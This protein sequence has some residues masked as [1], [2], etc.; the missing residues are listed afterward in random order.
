MQAIP[1]GEGRI[2]L[3][4]SVEDTGMGIAPEDKSRIFA[5]FEQT[6]QGRKREAGVG[7]GLAISRELAHRMGGVIEVDSQPGSGSRFSFS[8]VLPVVEVQEAVAPARLHIAGYEGKRRSILV[9]DDQEENRQLLRRM[10]ELLG[11]DVVLAGD[12][13]EAIAAARERH[14]DLIMMDLR[15]PGT[16]GFEAARIIRSMPGLETVPLMAASASTAD[17]EHAE[18]DP[19][20]FA[21]C[22]RKPF[23]TSDLIDAIERSLHLKWRY[24]QPGGATAAEQPQ[25]RL[26]APPR[27]VLITLLELA[28][29]GKLVRVEQMALELEREDALR[30]F[31]R[32]VYGLA[33]RLDEEELITLLEEYLGAQRDAVTE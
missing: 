22:L 13:R 29:L 33:R 4:V 19:T 5:P 26:V 31:A 12:G 3:R 30:P 21:A 14:P 15:M 8:V 23:Q 6:E 9:A 27:D 16:S 32:H 2:E 20:T 18:A 7:L 28:R 17:L 1:A 24:V 25:T 10:L 11:F